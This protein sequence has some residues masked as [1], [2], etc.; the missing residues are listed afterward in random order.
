V[1]VSS[2]SYGLAAVAFAALALACRRSRNTDLRLH[3]PAA[4]TSLWALLAALQAGVG[5]GMELVALAETLRDLAWLWLLWQGIRHLHG[6]E[7]VDRLGLAGLR[8]GLIFL[9]LASLL[10]QTAALI[11]PG[12]PTSHLAYEILP[13]L[14]A[15]A[16]IVMVEQYYRNSPPQERWGIKF[17]CLALGGQRNL[18]PQRSCGGELR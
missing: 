14:L 13:T 11:V 7:T 15:I 5:A 2:A 10:A 4:A 12:R 3:Y 1:L 6:T 9:S 16:G 18:M 17:L 8:R